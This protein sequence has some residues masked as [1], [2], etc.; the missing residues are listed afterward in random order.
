MTTP[1]LVRH[2]TLGIGFGLG[3]IALF[4]GLPAE[5]PPSWAAE[6]RT[7]WLGA[8]LVAFLLPTAAVIIDWLLR[9]LSVDSTAEASEQ[10]ASL[11]IYDALVA[12]VTMLVVGVHVVV[13]AALAGLLAGRGWAAQ[14]VPVMLGLAMISIGNLLPR[15]RPNLAIGIRTRR[16]LADRACWSRTHRLAGY[17]LVICGF[18]IVV[19]TLAIPGPH[20]PRAALLVGPFWVASTWVLVWRAGRRVDA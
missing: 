9:P 8:P 1:R 5:V 16:T 18:A 11:T 2:V 17:V 3:A 20:G 13:L 10:Q 15:T 19:A 7:V 12:R 4:A 6:G 14:L